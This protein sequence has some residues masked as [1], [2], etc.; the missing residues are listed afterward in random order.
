AADREEDPHR[1]RAPTPSRENG[2]CAK[3]SMRC[4][5]RAR[6]DRPAAV[7]SWRY[8]IFRYLRSNR[9]LGIYAKDVASYSRRSFGRSRTILSPSRVIL[10]VDAGEFSVT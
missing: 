5:A 9:P 8:R 4:A 2:R 10:N 1:T 7:L 3:I 6:R